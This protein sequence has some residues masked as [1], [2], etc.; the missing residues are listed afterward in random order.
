MSEMSYFTLKSSQQNCAWYLETVSYLI[1][2]SKKKYHLQEP[3]FFLNTRIFNTFHLN[4]KLFGERD[5]EVRV[6]NVACFQQLFFPL[7]FNNKIFVPLCCQVVSSDDKNSH[8]LC[9]V[10]P[11]QLLCFIAL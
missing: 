1:D 2:D 9:L 5:A 10:L 7:N 4:L 6:G 3:S 11:L 8:F